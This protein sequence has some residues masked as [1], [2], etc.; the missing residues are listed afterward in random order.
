M[1]L[2]LAAIWAL[3]GFATICFQ[4]IYEGRDFASCMRQALLA[5]VIAGGLGFIVGLVVKQVVE[6]TFVPRTPLPQ[7]EGEERVGGADQ[8]SSSASETAA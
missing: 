4:G 6:E 3:I 2:R 7:P 5:Y 8:T 1:S